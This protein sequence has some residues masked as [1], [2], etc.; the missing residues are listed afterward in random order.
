MIVLSNEKTNM[1]KISFFKFLSS[2]VEKIEVEYFKY[3]QTP[4]TKDN[5]KKIIISVEESIGEFFNKM[6][7]DNV[8]LPEY[9]D[10]AIEFSFEFN[11]DEDELKEV[12]TEIKQKFTRIFTKTKTKIRKDTIKDPIKKQQTYMPKE[13]SYQLILARS[14]YSFCITKVFTIT[15][16]KAEFEP[17]FCKK[18]LKILS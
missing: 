10:N 16:D 13:V 4:N 9:N 15:K 17:F 18:I 3:Y 6:D 2:Q 8:E 1:E 12:D 11:N 14:N 5:L 7:I